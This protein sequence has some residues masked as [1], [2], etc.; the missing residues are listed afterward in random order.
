MFSRFRGIDKLASPGDMVRCRSEHER[1][2]LWESLGCD[3][4]AI[5]GQ[6]EP[7]EILL[8]LDVRQMQDEDAENF[9][10]E[11]TVG[12]YLVYS[13]RGISGWVGAGWVVPV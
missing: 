8:I 13:P 1:L 2:F 12:A 6:T 3:S 10:D 11:W 9:A 4:D 5:N 7:N